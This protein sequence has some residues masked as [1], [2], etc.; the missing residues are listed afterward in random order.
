MATAR[1]RLAATAMFSAPISAI[2]SA[3]RMSMNAEWGRTMPV[4]ASASVTLWPTVNPVMTNSRS[5]NR[6]EIRTKPSTNDR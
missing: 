2:V 5:G 3:I 6:R 1:G 4:T